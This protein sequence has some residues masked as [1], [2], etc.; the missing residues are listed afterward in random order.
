MLQRINPVVSSLSRLQKVPVGS[1]VDM[2]WPILA[3]SLNRQ[4]IP[5][6]TQQTTINDLLVHIHMQ[7]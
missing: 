1:S 2:S 4:F 5:A 3:P 7:K 6:L